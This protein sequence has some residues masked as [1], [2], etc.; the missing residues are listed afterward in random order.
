MEIMKNRFCLAA[1]RIRHLFDNLDLRGKASESS[2]AGRIRLRH[3]NCLT[4]FLAHSAISIAS[5]FLASG[6]LAGFW[7]KPSK[8]PFQL[9]TDFMDSLEILQLLMKPIIQESTKLP[10]LLYPVFSTKESVQ[11][12]D[13]LAVL[14]GNPEFFQTASVKGLA[15]LCS[16]AIAG[17]MPINE[18]AI[19]LGNSRWSEA[20]CREDAELLVRFASDCHGRVDMGALSIALLLPIIFIVDQ[21]KYEKFLSQEKIETGTIEADRLHL[22]LC[23]HSKQ[24]DSRSEKEWLLA[25]QSFD[26]YWRGHIQIRFFQKVH[27]KIDL[28]LFGN[29]LSEGR[30]QKGVSQKQIASLEAFK[31]FVT[32]NPKI[33]YRTAF[34]ALDTF[35]RYVVAGNNSLL[36]HE[37]S[38]PR[39]A[40]RQAVRACSFISPDVYDVD[41]TLLAI[42]EKQS[43]FADFVNWAQLLY[44]PFYSLGRPPLLEIQTCFSRSKPT[45]SRILAQSSDAVSSWKEELTNQLLRFSRSPLDLSTPEPILQRTSEN[46]QR[47]FCKIKFLSDALIKIQP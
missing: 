38:Y 4:G 44:F 46:P 27:K 11:L 30:K 33:F 41:S 31:D 17:N 34:F 10:L 47:S 37:L 42:G 39:Q 24:I 19:C 3:E 7:P 22:R 2:A 35:N 23:F 43:T 9:N 28:Y 20:F 18:T 1:D 8:Q 25:Y 29:K 6:S 14:A 5:A 32:A 13:V 40:F 16:L 36:G 26:P 45:R 21:R 15:S 12:P